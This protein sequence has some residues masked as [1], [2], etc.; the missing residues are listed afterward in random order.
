MHK[1]AQTQTQKDIFKRFEEATKKYDDKDLGETISA[2][3]TIGLITKK[4]KK[5][6]Q[7]I[8][9]EVFRNAYSHATMSKTFGETTVGVQEFTLA[10]SEFNS[11][12]NVDVK[13]MNFPLIRGLIQYVFA[14]EDCVPYFRSVDETVRHMLK[15]LELGNHSEIK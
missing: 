7:D 2:A 1:H 13:A 10:K 8:F 5:L 9:R 15:Q 12:E 3:C 6:L 14:K 4:Q 11:G